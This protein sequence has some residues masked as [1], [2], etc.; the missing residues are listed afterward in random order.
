M[1]T[2]LFCLTL[3][4]SFSASARNTL[5]M[6]CMMN[7]EMFLHVEKETTFGGSGE[8]KLVDSQDGSLSKTLIEGETYQET[9]VAPMDEAS[10]FIFEALEIDPASIT[11]FKTAKIDGSV[12]LVQYETTSRIVTAIMAP[13][14]LP[15]LC[16]Y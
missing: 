11:M 14:S 13:M 12:T 10:L 3:L 4:L 8:I 5:L 9:T 7:G 1:K 15:M 2:I 6:Q 16:D